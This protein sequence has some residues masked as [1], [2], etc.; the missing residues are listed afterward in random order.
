MGNK[1]SKTFIQADQWQGAKGNRIGSSDSFKL[2]A[3]RMQGR[4]GTKA[5]YR[6]P[7]QTPL[8]DSIYTSSQPLSRPN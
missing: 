3:A 1:F 4:G 7:A 2:C 5:N 6:S 8:A